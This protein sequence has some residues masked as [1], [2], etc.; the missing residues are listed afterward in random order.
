MEIMILTLILIVLFINV[1][2]I[3][4]FLGK[5]SILTGISEHIQSSEFFN[6]D[7]QRLRTGL[8]TLKIQHYLFL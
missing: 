8:L 5:Y 3:H 2:E 7:K 6:I 4:S 1:K